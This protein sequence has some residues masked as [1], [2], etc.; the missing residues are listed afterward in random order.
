MKASDRLEQIKNSWQELSIDRLKKDVSAGEVRKMIRKKSKGE[1]TK[2]KRKLLIETILSA[3]LLPVILVYIHRMDSFFAY[4]TDAFLIIYSGALAFPTMR[5]LRI[6]RLKNQETIIFLRKFVYHFRKAIRTG[7]IILVVLFPIYFIA[8]FIIGFSKGYEYAGNSHF[9][10]NTIT[11]LDGSAIL[12][13]AAIVV[14]VLMVIGFL[15]LIKLYYMLM[16][17]KHIRNLK[18]FLADLERHEA[19]DDAEKRPTSN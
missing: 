14:L 2:I 9:N 3:V 10:F 1:L 15:F 5:I 8:A 13:G 4:I 7:A 16:Y 11:S 17:G 18:N 19:E 12:I 6:G